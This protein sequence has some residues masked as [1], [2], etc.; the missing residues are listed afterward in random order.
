MNYQQYKNIILTTAKKSIAYGLKHHSRTTL[1][2]K[3]IPAALLENGACFVTLEIHQ[4]LRGCIGN[5]EAFQPLID[6]IS[7][8]AYS[9]AFSD[10]RFPAV[11]DKEFKQLSIHVSILSPATAIQFNNEQDLIAS[12]KPGIDGLIL[13]DNGRRGTF[14]PSVWESLPEPEDFLRHLKLKAGLTESHW[15]DSI[16][17]SR[18]QTEMIE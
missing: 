16:K 14:L 9:A 11:T 18:Y 17:V 2:H 7:H 13:E 15:S 5:L 4:Q 8:N 6:D 10:P 12:I 3:N 1:D